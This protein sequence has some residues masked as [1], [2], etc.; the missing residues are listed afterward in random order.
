MEIVDLKGKQGQK[1]VLR[2]QGHSH[3]C[4]QWRLRR[5]DTGSLCRSMPNDLPEDL[6]SAVCI[7]YSAR[8]PTSGTLHLPESWVKSC[9]CTARVWR[10]ARKWT[11]VNIHKHLCTCYKE[12]PT[13]PAK[14]CC[15][16]LREWTQMSGDVCTLQ[17]F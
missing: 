13:N 4:E 8:R 7:P 14:S 17:P 6:M 16:G 10:A 3:C 1:P 11:S 2:S 9:H 5:Q 12:G 15:S